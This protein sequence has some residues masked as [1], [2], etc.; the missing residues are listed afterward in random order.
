MVYPGRLSYNER[1]SLGIGRGLIGC[2]S[3]HHQTHPAGRGD[4]EYPGK[5]EW[6]P[7]DPGGPGAPGHPSVPCWC[8]SVPSSG[9]G[10]LGPSALEPP[11]NLHPTSAPWVQNS[12]NV[13]QLGVGPHRKGRTSVRIGTQI[14]LCNLAPRE[15]LGSDSLCCIMKVCCSNCSQFSEKSSN[16][17]YFCSGSQ[18]ASFFQKFQFRRGFAGKQLVKTEFNF[19]GERKALS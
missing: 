9:E 2:N 7:A 14:E 5:G 15:E 4:G 16:P 11:K 1:F 8:K 17:K 12:Q 6:Y 18:N 13:F 10:A 3:V 19:T